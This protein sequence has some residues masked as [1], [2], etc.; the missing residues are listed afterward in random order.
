MRVQLLLCPSAEPEIRNPQAGGA[1]NGLPLCS[2]TK[3][4]AFCCSWGS[5]RTLCKG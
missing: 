2:R 4:H 1:G 5:P 3:A